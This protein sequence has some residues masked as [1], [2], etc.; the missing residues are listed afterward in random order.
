VGKWWAETDWNHLHYILLQNISRACLNR[1]RTDLLWRCASELE[2]GE[3]HEDL[4][5]R[6]CHKRIHAYFGL[7][8]DVGEL[9]SP[10]RA[11][12]RTIVA[13]K[14]LVTSY[15]HARNVIKTTVQIEL[16]YYFILKLCVWSA[17][18]VLIIIKPLTALTGRRE[19]SLSTSAH[20]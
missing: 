2:R 5:M 12:L 20:R 9:R 11:I 15:K 16:Q 4:L 7:A 1:K 6:G 8:I 17:R 19:R 13:H 18:A 14:R 10:E 3:R